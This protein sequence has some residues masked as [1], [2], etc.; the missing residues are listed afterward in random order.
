MMVHQLRSTSAKE[1]R[2]LGNNA[3]HINS[4]CTGT[5]RMCMRTLAGMHVDVPT[6]YG[7]S[8]NVVMRRLLQ[9]N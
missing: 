9:L 4:W 3:L 2:E 6:R 5:L 8:T 1:Q 7:A